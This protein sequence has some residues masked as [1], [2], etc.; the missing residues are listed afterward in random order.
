LFTPDVVI[1]VLK[2]AVAAVTVL[3]LAS[4]MALARGNKRLHGRINTVFFALTLTAVLGLELIIRFVNPEFSA[5][6]SAE[7]RRA[8][9]I[10]LGFAAPAALVLPLMLYSGK[11]HR[12]WHVS[13]SVLFSVLWAGTFVTGIFF[14]PYPIARQ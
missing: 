7:E 13:L 1:P 14:L 10:H 5:G 3:L 4:L 11:A 2:V 12:R 6:F 8:L 9:N